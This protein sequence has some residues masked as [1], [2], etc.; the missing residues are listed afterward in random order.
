[1]T[2]SYEYYNTFDENA[3]GEINLEEQVYDWLWTIELMIEFIKKMKPEILVTF[4]DAVETKYTMDLNQTSYALS[5]V[6]FDE[7]AKDQ[8]ILGQYTSIKNLGLQLIMKYIPQLEGY[9][10]DSRGRA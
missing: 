1:M 10:R 6:G 2:G 3:T 9:S 8:S 5:N 7:I 4:L